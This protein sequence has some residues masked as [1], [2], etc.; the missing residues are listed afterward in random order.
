[1]VI[2]IVTS[3][4]VDGEYIPLLWYLFPKRGNLAVSRLSGILAG[5]PCSGKNRKRQTGVKV[6]AFECTI[7]RDN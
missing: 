5:V 2:Q 6:N 7:P 1:M 3:T 4:Y